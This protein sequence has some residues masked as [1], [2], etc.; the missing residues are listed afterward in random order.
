MRLSR[1]FAVPTMLATLAL[2]LA[3]RDTTAQVGT[4]AKP[5]VV[6]PPATLP[7]PVTG[8][9]VPKVPAPAGAA[10]SPLFKKPLNTSATK[11]RGFVDLHTHPMA[12][13]AMGGKLMH[14]APDVGVLMPAGS[15]WSAGG[16]CNAAPQAAQNVEQ[17]L[18]SCYASHA[19]HDLIKNKCGNH[20]RRVVINEFENGKHTNKPH[21][22]DHPPGF[23][24]FTKWPKYNDIIHQ[25]MWI[26]WIKRAH[27]GGLRVMVAL[28]VNSMTLAKGLAGNEP[29]DD[30]T[31]GDTQITEMKKMIAKPANRAWMEIAYT[32][33]D[34]RRI[35]GQD[36]LAI[37]LG[38]ELDDIGNFAWSK[39]EPTRAEVRAEIDRLHRQG[40]RYIFPVHVIDNY[41]GG[42]A[43]YEAEFPRA[44][45]YHFGEWPKIVCASASD[46]I[47]ARISNGGDLFKLFALGDAGGQFSVPNCPAGVGFKNA[48][49]LQ[50][51]GRFAVDEMMA[52]GMIIDVDHGSQA[53]VNDLLAHAA[54]KP[55]GYP[56]VS[57]HNGL[58][59]AGAN[60]NTRTA[61]QYRDIAARGGIVGVGFGDSDAGRYMTS[62]RQVLGA[63]PNTLL[64]LGS[65]INGFVVMPTA[66]GCA[67]KRCVQYDE[68]FPMATM[69]SKRWDYNT[70]GV[71]HIGLFPDFLR[72]VE[73]D[74][75]KDIVERLF[76][77]AEGVAKMWE[78]AES[79]GRAVRS[80]APATFD[81][82][83]A[84]VR[85]KSDDVRDGARAWIS[86]Q[87]TSGT[88]PEEEITNL[89]K[90]ANA[91]KQTAIRLPRA[92]R[93]TDVIAVNVRHFSNDCLAC[94]RDYWEGSVELEGAGG[95]TILRTPDFR[96]GHE[97][98]TFRR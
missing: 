24:A 70:D 86:I 31:S 96:I 53:T 38:S 54:S 46:G 82:V 30:K 71:A 22:E 26:D 33:A 74:G 14:G 2:V 49:N 10:A 5:Q 23:P 92:V 84:I 37:V 65:D 48:R 1:T 15:I 45:K 91:Q 51:L 7:K 47:G 28:S 79:V 60:E 35:V 64:N 57:G 88:L 40:I 20:V 78:R 52:R 68:S 16:N 69:G 11:L 98:K 83:Q 9:V 62:V 50:P 97:T 17:A 81:S 90:G 93:V 19:G 39:R 44:S 87:L 55:G 29:Y 56:V 73:N 8:V 76:D 21:N 12:H 63:A 43:I 80:A 42:T 66:S 72:H 59:G 6:P 18:G 36:K 4:I 25:Q 61:Q 77:G 58:R 41:F 34:L 67:T 75:G 27:Q 95:Q 85:T 89:A 3:T 32:A 13:L 94:A